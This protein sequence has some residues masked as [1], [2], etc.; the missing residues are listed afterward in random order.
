M[1]GDGGDVRMVTTSE[2]TDQGNEGVEMASLMA[3]RA[4]LIELYD[5]L[6]DGTIAAIRV[7]HWLCF[8]GLK[9]HKHG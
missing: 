6:L 4:G 2:A 3:G 8:S 7:T 5:A 1:I 9:G